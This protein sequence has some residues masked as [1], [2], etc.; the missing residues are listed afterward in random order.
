MILAGRGWGKTRTISEWCRAQIEAGHSRG[1]LIARTSADARDV[2][3]EGESGLLSIC[4]PFNRPVYEPSKRRVVWPSGQ[5]MTLY[6]AEEPDSLRGPQHSFLALDELA[7]WP[8]RD[9]FD[10]AMFG[11]RLGK[12]PRTVIAT[13]P[14]PT[15]LIRELVARPDV[16]VTKGSTWDNAE[17]LPE[18]FLHQLRD[19][20]QGTR[21][22][23][24][25]ID[26]EILLDTP[27]A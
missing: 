25:E 5:M 18:G 14:R 1:G 2:L 23:R 9:A 4:P 21:L 19:R 24:Q 26:A 22:G 16:A 8:S 10:Q 17:N 20:Y 13:T 27:G 7:T 11:L 6:S 3:I 12:N 15:P